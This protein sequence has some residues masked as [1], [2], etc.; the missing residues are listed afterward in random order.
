VALVGGN[1]TNGKTLQNF[2][3]YRSNPFLSFLVVLRGMPRKFQ[4]FIS[5]AILISRWC[6]DA[7]GGINNDFF[8]TAA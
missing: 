5:I 1:Q 8:L 3:L 7:G 2:E 6:C 4:K